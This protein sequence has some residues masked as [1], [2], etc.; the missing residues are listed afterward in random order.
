MEFALPVIPHQ[1]H[2][3]FAL[4]VH[5]KVGANRLAAGMTPATISGSMSIGLAVSAEASFP[6]R[7]STSIPL[8]RCECYEYA[9]L[10]EKPGEGQGGAPRNQRCHACPIPGRF[11]TVG[12]GLTLIAGTFQTRKVSLTSANTSPFPLSCDRLDNTRAA[13]LTRMTAFVSQRGRT[14]STR[15]GTSIGGKRGSHKMHRTR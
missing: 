13:P 4:D 1:W 11:R 7:S 8:S 9:N 10:A 15:I 3:S 6:E 5:A 12:N 2:E 14:T